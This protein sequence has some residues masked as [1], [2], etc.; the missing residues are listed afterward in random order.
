[1]SST[2]K[3]SLIKKRLIEFGYEENIA[4]L[5]SV[6]MYTPES[7]TNPEN[8]SDERFYAKV[9]KAIKQFYEQL[10]EPLFSNSW[11]EVTDEELIYGRV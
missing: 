11:M 5:L 10:E 9:K 8:W 4:E 3:L 6:R 7:K 2:S 1:M